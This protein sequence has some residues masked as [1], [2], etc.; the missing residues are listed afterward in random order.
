MEAFNNFVE[1]YYIVFAILSVV[2][3]LA[4]IGYFI[5]KKAYAKKLSKTEELKTINIQQQVQ[6]MGVTQNQSNFENQPTQ[7]VQPQVQVQS[8]VQPQNF[9]QA[10]STVQAQNTVQPQSTVQAQFEPQP[11]Q[12]VQQTAPQSTEQTQQTS[13]GSNIDILG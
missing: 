2:L 10:Q 13:S 11:T 6:Q 12:T 1:K 8:T 5:E 7:T 4:L 9:V 3:I